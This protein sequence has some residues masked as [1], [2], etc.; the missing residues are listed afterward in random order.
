MR[1]TRPAQGPRSRNHSGTYI[2]RAGRRHTGRKTS[3][4]S[5]FPG[6]CNNHPAD[7]WHNTRH[8]RR[9]IQHR[10][11]LCP[12]NRL[13]RPREPATGRPPEPRSAGWNVRRTCFNDRPECGGESSGEFSGTGLALSDLSGGFLDRRGRPVRGGVGIRK[14]RLRRAERKGRAKPRRRKGNSE[15]ACTALRLRDFARVPFGQPS[16]GRELRNCQP[17]RPGPDLARMW[18]SVGLLRQSPQLA[19]CC[20]AHSGRHRGLCRRLPV[21]GGAIAGGRGK[22]ICSA[23]LCRKGASAA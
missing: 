11:R 20:Q 13:Q 1:V 21:D 7:R 4:P 6:C 12:P 14:G 9:R 16:M 3:H 19:E 18:D 2:R 22:P 23:N 10:S 17:R 8:S 5:S 15:A